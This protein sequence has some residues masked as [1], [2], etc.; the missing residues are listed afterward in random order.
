MD[1]ESGTLDGTDGGT[2]TGGTYIA[3]GSG[4]V[5]LTGGKSPTFT[6][7]YTGSGNGRVQ[8][9][10]GTFTVGHGGATFNFPSGL[11]VFSGGTLNGA[12]TNAS[13]GY[14]TIKGGTLGGTINNQGTITQTS[15]TL[16]LNGSISN[17]G[18]DDIALSV[19]G[20]VDTGGGTLTNT[21]T[22]TLE[23][24]STVTATLNEP[25]RQ[26]G[27]P[28]RDHN[29]GWGRHTSSGRWRREYRRDVRFN[30]NWVTHRLG[31]RWHLGLNRYLLG[32]GV[33]GRRDDARRRH[34]AGSRRGHAQL[35]E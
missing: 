34:R 25:I 19:S 4:V 31:G 26:P 12:L 5:D 30:G 24:T 8:L 13:T 18:T 21:S 7:T 27:W 29:L 23:L 16:T 9:A 1:A 14:L 15:G 3:N 22:G 35:H 28:G 2:N 10:S 11:L 32:H 33:G 17:A 6:G 20:T